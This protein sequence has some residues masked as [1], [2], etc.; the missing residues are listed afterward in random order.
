MLVGEGVA[1]ARSQPVATAVTALV[2]G[3]VCAVILATVGQSAAAEARVLDT[4][5]E[6]GSRI[7]VVSDPNG[8]A[9]MYA[10]SV[11]VVLALDRVEWALGLGPVIDVRNIDL[12][13][14]ARPVPARRY[15]G[16]LPSEVSGPSPAVG[17]ALVG[18]DAI[19][20]LGVREPVAG[21]AGGDVSAAVVGRFDAE[22]PLAFLERGVLIAATSDPADQSRHPRS[23]ARLRQLYVM[24]D[25]VEAVDQL[26]RAVRVVVHADMPQALAV[27][28]PRLLVE[29]RAVIGSELAANSRRLMLLVLAVGLAI[30]AITLAGAVSQ[31]RRDFGRRRA[32]G[33]TRS[34]IAVLVQTQ[35]AVGAILGVIV[36][37]I[38]GLIAVWRM[39]GSLPSATFIAGVAVLTLLTAL[40]AGLPPAVLAAFRDPVRVLRLP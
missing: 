40:V 27:E 17:E 1:V 3:A 15:Y 23:P 21:I 16:D 9:G 10:D 22:E 37:C 26:V 34:A 6:A 38:I 4:I 19:T 5:D 14:A 11:E 24:A 12:G 30:V 31:R 29:L 20:L 7:I 33:A 39:A 2:V 32:L 8:R 28:S 13:A 25:N 35:T 18:T 36:G